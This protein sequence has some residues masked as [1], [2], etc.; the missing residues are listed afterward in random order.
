[1]S[2][3]MW[4]SPPKHATRVQHKKMM[5]TPTD[6]C[7]TDNV[8]HLWKTG[9]SAFYQ[10]PQGDAH[11]QRCTE[12]PRRRKPRGTVAATGVLVTPHARALLGTMINNYEVLVHGS[13]WMELSASMAVLDDFGFL[14][15]I[16]EIRWRCRQDIHS[17]HTT[18]Q[19]NP[20][21][22]TERIARAWFKSQCHL[23]APE[24]SP[25]TVRT[26][27]TRCSLT[28]RLPRAH[29]LPHSLFLP[30]QHKNTQHNR[31]NTII[32]S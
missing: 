16:A 18:V 13:C 17:Q 3:S 20:F 15:R 22:K 12:A 25:V 14:E 21:T 23:C 6:K 31:D 19:N 29:H 26:C 9:W 2:A 4:P 28:C 7:T 11:P 30:P 1:M 27:L 32:S 10:I 24:K 8:F 5:D